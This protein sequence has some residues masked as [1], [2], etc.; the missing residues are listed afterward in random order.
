MR[1]LVFSSVFDDLC[2]AHEQLWKATA[3]M[4]ALGLMAVV[5]VYVVA[6]EQSPAV[7][8]RAQAGSWAADHTGMK[9]NVAKRTRRDSKRSFRASFREQAKSR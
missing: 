7:S 6:S 8:V 1:Y 3:P 4:I 9:M 2:P 5:A